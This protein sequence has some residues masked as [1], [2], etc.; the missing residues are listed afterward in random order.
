LIRREFIRSSALLGLGLAIGLPGIALGGPKQESAAAISSGKKSR[1][2]TYPRGGCTEAG[3]ALF[4]RGPCGG[5]P[6]GFNY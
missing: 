3:H 1:G 4:D 5:D 2:F 6:F